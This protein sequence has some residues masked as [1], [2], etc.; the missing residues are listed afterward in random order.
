M[1]Y[2]FKLYAFFTE[3]RKLQEDI[4][5]GVCAFKEVKLWIAAKRKVPFTDAA[6]QV[7]TTRKT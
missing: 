2:L 5:V 3:S 1:V 7:S 4:R 6:A